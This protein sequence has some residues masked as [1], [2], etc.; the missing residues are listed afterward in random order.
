M[1]NTLVLSQAEAET[2]T[3]INHVYSW[4]TAGLA[5]TGAVAWYMAAN[6]AMMISLVKIR[7]LF[8]GLLIAELILV[9]Y[10]AIWLKAMSAF[11][12]SAVFV[13]YAVLNGVTISIIF[14]VYTASS[15]ASTFFVTAGTFGLMSLYGYTTKTDLTTV[16]NL[17][18]MGLVGI[19]MASLVN[20]FLHNAAVYWITTYLGILV[21]VG[22]TAYDTQKIKN[23]NIIGNEGTDEDK[24]EAISGALTLYL[25]F[26]NLFLSLLRATGKRR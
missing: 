2:R 7:F 3:F 18:F 25:D 12:A 22:L 15:I 11:T 4:M 19:I 5:V 16:G 14:L 9:A 13:A 1:E 21:F 26:I 24:K 23:L 8:F 6:P 20:F 10:L 17:C